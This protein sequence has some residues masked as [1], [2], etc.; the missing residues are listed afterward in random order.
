V[1]ALFYYDAPTWSGSARAFVAYGRGLAERGYHVTFVCQAGAVEARVEAEGGDVV[2][3]EGGARTIMGAAWQLRRVLHDRFVETIFVHG[4][5]EH[6]VAAFAT[7]WAKRGA[8]IRRTPTGGVLVAGRDTRI[9]ARLASTSYVFTTAGDAQAAPVIPRAR[10]VNTVELGV[11]AARYDEIR[12]ADPASLGANGGEDGRLLV[13]VYDRGGKARAA[14]VIRAVAALAPRHPELHLVL[15]GP[16]ASHE[17][18]RMHAAALG[19]GS[20]VTHVEQRDDDL[21]VLRAADIGWVVA[22]EDNG[23]F[24]ALDFMALRTPVLVERGTVAARY[25]AD[26][27]TG[28]VL[29][30]GD[31]PAVAATIAELLAQPEQRSAMG[32]A[33]RARV[34]REYSEATMLDGLVSAVESARDRTAWKAR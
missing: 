6:L 26:G 3:L 23:A 31:T 11:D 20:V 28:V 12:G 13:C 34:A 22:G 17:D 16:G 4:Q 25:V 29:P 27:I 5:R 7:R 18:L 24:G 21:A 8:I 30:P 19:V 33:G 1:R 2:P 14:T 9:A 32:H 15:F 10:E